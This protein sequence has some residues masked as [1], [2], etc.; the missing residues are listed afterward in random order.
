VSP[1][2]IR[3]EIDLSALA[4][5]VSELRRITS[6][7]AQ[8]MAVVKANGYGHGAEAVARTALENGADRLALAR[9]DEA[10]ELRRAGIDAPMLVFGYTPPERVDALAEN[11]LIQTV[12]S[13]AVA[14]E[15]SDAASAL[16]RSL[17]VHIKVDTGM[18]RFGLLAVDGEDAL[19]EAETML[20]LPGLTVEGIYTHF[21]TADA[22]DKTLARNQL[23]RFMSFTGDLKKRGLVIPIRHAANSA[24]VI[25]MPESHLEMVRPGIS[26]YGLYPSG[27]VKKERLALKPAMTLKARIV[28]LKEVP[29]GCTI[30]YGATY[31]APAP[32]RIATIPVGYAD[33][34]DRLLSNQGHMVVR[35]LR[36]PIVGR[37]CMD[38]TMIDVSNIPGVQAGDDVAVFGGDA[39]NAVTVDE[40]AEKLGTINYEVVST[41]MARVPRVYVE[42]GLS[43]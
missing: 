33:G 40:V 2:P 16:G 31:T 12:P 37:V 35:G 34:F 38:S 19:D 10:L 29:E 28:Q 22:A 6:S 7:G 24:A 5:N 14:R 23:S 17:I 9:I 18:G 11:D 3:A 13:L 8:L 20:S 32:T 27:E 41:V 39:E 42:S 21:A 1:H 36:C 15:L 43:G 25:D 4:H 30:S 26:L